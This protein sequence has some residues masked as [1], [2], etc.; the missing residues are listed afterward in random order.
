VRKGLKSQHLQVLPHR[1]RLTGVIK[2]VSESLGMHLQ[3]NKSLYSPSFVYIIPPE[4][5]FAEHEA[6]PEGPTKR[7]KKR[8]LKPP[9]HLYQLFHLFP[10][11]FISPLV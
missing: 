1:F 9:V 2:P 3:A 11:L 6:A 10:N 8:S 5:L 7:R 4:E